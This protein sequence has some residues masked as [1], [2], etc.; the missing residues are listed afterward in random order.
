VVIMYFW[1]VAVMANIDTFWGLFPN[2]EEE[3]LGNQ[4]HT[5]PRSPFLTSSAK[6]SQTPLISISG[7]A[8][9]GSTVKIYVNEA[10]SGHTLADREG[11]FRFDNVTLLEG[12]NRLFATATDNAQNTSPPSPV[13]T[14]FYLSQPP[15][16]ELATP[17]EGQV[18]TQKENGLVVRGL[19]DREATVTINNHRA[20]VDSQGLFSYTA[21]LQE[22]ENRLLVVARDQ[23]GNENVLERNIIYYKP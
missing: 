23:A 13:A 20:I 11:T 3:G 4:D 2:A 19:T 6:Y 16:L 10:E 17:S 21:Y 1:F 7:Y 22:G 12:E 14:I 18:I 15:K 5:P 9:E 8:E